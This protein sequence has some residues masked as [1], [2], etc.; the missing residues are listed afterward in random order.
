MKFLNVV[1]DTRLRMPL[2]GFVIFVA[3]ANTVGFS[4][5]LGVPGVPVSPMR[6]GVQM[7]GPALNTPGQLNPS[8][9]GSPGHRGQFQGQG[10]QVVNRNV[11][12]NFT[13]TPTNSNEFRAGAGG[14]GIVR[15]SQGIVG[16]STAVPFAPRR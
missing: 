1:N 11:G 4:Q 13:G 6:A 2:L 9:R 5:G 10:A 8:L 14:S 7:S 15:N 16:Q 3:N 12:R